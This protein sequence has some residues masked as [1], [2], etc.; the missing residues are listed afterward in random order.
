MKKLMWRWHQKYHWPNY[1]HDTITLDNSNVD[2][3]VN[4]NGNNAVNNNDI[5]A[6]NDNDK[7]VYREQKWYNHA[8]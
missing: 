4:D 3:G 8:I 2:N 5:N 6:D 7:D 1:K